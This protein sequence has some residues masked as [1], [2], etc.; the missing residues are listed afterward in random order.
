MDFDLVPAE[1]KTFNCPLA[2]VPTNR[3]EPLTSSLYAP[4]CQT[5][6]SEMF[7]KGVAI[8]RTAICQCRRCSRQYLRS[9]LC[10]ENP[11]RPSRSRRLPSA[12]S[13]WPNRCHPLERTETTKTPCLDNRTCRNREAAQRRLDRN[14][15]EMLHPT[16]FFRRIAVRTRRF[17]PRRQQSLPQR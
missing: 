4:T 12:M 10:Q 7:Q 13:K 16:R 9:Y 2:S 1:S 8:L 14:S 5:S 17:V 3:Q 11:P 6:P 15:E